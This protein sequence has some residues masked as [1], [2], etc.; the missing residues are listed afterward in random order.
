M[1]T[2][3]SLIRLSL[4][5]AGTLLWTGTTTPLAAQ[6]S[7]KLDPVVLEYLNSDI[8]NNS[9]KFEE[10]RDLEDGIR[11]PWMHLT[12]ES[13]DGATELDL[14][15]VNA[16]RD[17]ARYTLSF[18]KPGTYGVFLDYNKIPHNFANDAHM[19]YAQTGKGTLEIA[20]ATQLAL[21]TAIAN[22]PR[23]NITFAFL[24]NL[25]APYL[26]NANRL[27]IGLQRDRGLARVNLGSLGPWGFGI[28]VT[29]ESRKGNRAYGGS[30]GFSNATE[31]PEPIDYDTSGAEIA[32]EWNGKN[33]GLRLGYRYSKF[34]N[35]VSTLVWDN[36]FRITDATDPNA[37][38]APGSGSIGGAAHG[39]ADLAPDN[40]A[41][42]LFL[43]GRTRLGTWVLS[44]NL[45]R[46]TM[47]QNDPLLP[48]TL[49]TAIRGIHEDGST[50]DPTNVA[51]LPIRR[52]DLKVDVTEGAAQLGTHF[53]S[54]W[55]LTFRYRYYDYDDTSHRVEFPGYVRYH[56]VW[57]EI[58]RITVPNLYTVQNAGT[59]IGW[60]VLRST[61]L[62]LAYNRETWDRKLRE[63]KTSDEDVFKLSLDTRPT[64]RWSIRGSYE[65]GDRSIGT[66]DTNASEDS[67]LEVGGVS[68]NLPGLRKFDE[69][70]RTYDSYKLL[71]QW[72]ATDAWNL[73]FGVNGRNED[74][75][76]S[77]FGLVSDDITSYN[78]ELSYAPNDALNVYAFGQRSDRDS[79]QRARQ[80]GATPSTNPLDTW[81]ADLQEV[82]DT[83]GLGLTARFA[84]S[85]STDVQWNWSKSN[86]KADL[87]SPP[88]GTPDAA[89]GFDNYEDIELKALLARLDYRI[90][91]HFAAGLSYRWEDYTIDSFILQGL[92]TYLPGA[93]LL[94]GDNGSYR[95]KVY[96]VSFSLFF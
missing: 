17:D 53:G 76:K 88:G 22:A 58:G 86:G 14:Q 64:D 24:N 61:H 29:Q 72:M 30:F 77:A 3:S 66:Y 48:Y 71:A 26:A 56:A 10:Y 50:F 93:L 68:T 62:A 21:Q 36:P 73:S 2:K 80:S 89:V 92:R 9:A 63:I 20:D 52:A 84:K 1:S 33:S 39:F 41:D 49:N 4:L 85:W 94:N 45:F 28:E 79:F 23:P 75:K 87:F 46:E 67:F 38:T 12:G 34:E 13:K 55:D 78:A 8:N 60:N 42:M 37:Y 7:F 44:G 35:N 6:F 59:E 95:A 82:T 32:G 47:K 18:G 90:N 40:R 57:E 83:A 19:L 54:A 91:D 51:N 31:I 25:L 5:T 65:V 70:A 74:Y 96:S 81:T 11:I 69:A 43:D 16:V 27:D 15:V